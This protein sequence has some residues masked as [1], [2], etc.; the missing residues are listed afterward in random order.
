MPAACTA[1]ALPSA[2]SP[3]TTPAP[4]RNAPSAARSWPSPGPIARTIDDLRLGLLAMSRPDARDPW[5]VPA[6]LHRA[7]PA[8]PGRDVP[9]PRW[10]GHAARGLHGAAG[11]RRPPARCRL[12]RRRGR[13]NC[14]P[15]RTRWRSRSRCG[16]ATATTRWSRPPQ[17]RGRPGRDRGAGGPGRSGASRRHSG[18]FVGAVAAP[19]HRAGLA[20]VPGTL[21]GGAAA[22]ERGAALPRR[23]GPA[24]ARRPMRGCG[25]RRCR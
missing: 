15:C 5:W 4:P 17:A 16:W 8:A 10:P 18:V 6:P 11:R 21:S 20:V 7:G 13:A 12:D 2:G 24:R 1:C 3:P 19:G 25:A 23:P 22:G 9:A 14:R